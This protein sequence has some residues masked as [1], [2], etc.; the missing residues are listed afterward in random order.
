MRKLTIVL[1]LCLVLATTADAQEYTAPTA[2]ED[3]QQLMPVQTTSFGKDLWTIISRASQQLYP[4]LAKCSGICI[5]LIAVTM[6]ISMVQA[7]PGN[8]AVVVRLV[9]AI[10]AAGL[11]IGQTGTMIRSASDTVVELSEYGKL[12]LPVMASATAAQGAITSSTA[13]YAGT[14]LFTTILTVCIRQWIIPLITISLVLSVVGSATGQGTLD[15]LKGFVK[16]L[17]IWLLR[18]ILYIFTGYITITGVV[19]GTADVAALKA[20]KLTMS[21]MIPVVGGILSDASEAILVGA[22]VM[23][24]AAGVYGL[25]VI[26]AIWITPFIRI[27][28]RYLLLKFTA[29]ICAVFGVKQISDMIQAFSE[30]MGLLLAVTGGISIMLLISTVCFMK[31]V[32]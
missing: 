19:S 6:A 7:M 32:G 3:A 14:V 28:V 13:L 31:G 25:L 20:A 17:A 5:G 8:A 12:L 1:I 24:S 26:A 10:A 21:G 2:P 29:A 22:G 18:T 23:K 11:L 16:W 9:G 30:A 15:K 27:G 4:Q